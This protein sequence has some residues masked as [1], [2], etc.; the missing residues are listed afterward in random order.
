MNRVALGQGAPSHYRRPR[1][2]SHT[3]LTLY[4]THLYRTPPSLHHRRPRSRRPLLQRIFTMASMQ[5]DSSLTKVEVRPVV[6]FAILDHFTRRKEG[7]ER[8]VGALLGYRRTGGVEIVSCFAVPHEEK[9]ATDEVRDCE[10]HDGVHVQWLLAVAS[11]GSTRQNNS[12]AAAK[13]L[14]GRERRTDGLTTRI[15]A[16]KWAG[17]RTW[18]DS[19]HAAFILRGH[20]AKRQLF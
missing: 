18:G 13:G 16:G 3:R 17:E 12:G 20:E 15:C 6:A 10:R 14:A 9:A 1:T 8:V 2:P 19:A 11:A 4:T 7:Q 5:L